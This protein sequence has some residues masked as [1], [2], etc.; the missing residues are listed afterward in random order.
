MSLERSIS[1]FKRNLSALVLLAMRI[2]QE[3]MVLWLR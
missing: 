1:K 3:N 2:T